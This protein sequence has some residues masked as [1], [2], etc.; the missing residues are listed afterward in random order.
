MLYCGTHDGLY[1]V[2]DGTVD[3]KLDCGRVWSI[4]VDGTFVVAAT[5]AGLYWSE[6]G[7]SWTHSPIDGEPTA[8]VSVEGE[9]LVGTTP[10]GVYRGSVRQE[11]DRFTP[12]GDLAAHPHNKRW[13]DRAQ[14]SNAGVRTL[15]LHPEDGILAGLEP[16]GVYAYDGEFWRQYGDGVHDDVHDLLV[17]D[18]GD[19]V[20]ATGNGLYRTSNGEHWIRLDV[21]FR[22]FWA[23]YFREAVVHDGRLITSGNHV[24]PESPGGSV[25]DGP[26]DGD[27]R[28]DTFGFDAQ[29][30]PTAE[31]AFV[32]SWAAGE[33]VLYGGTMAVGETFKQDEPAQLLANRGDGWDS[34]AELPAGITALA[35]TGGDSGG[36]VN[37]E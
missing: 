27:D 37:V 4:A 13:N 32:T 24:G 20:A 19:V 29:S 25:L 10:V 8:V 18:D 9:L 11:G 17:L 2:E 6:D 3:P 35:A 21:D 5:E 33:G 22:D 31:P 36:G 7:D 14:P 28:T 34:V 1:T 16:G 26:V 30:V 15:S 12:V 23:N